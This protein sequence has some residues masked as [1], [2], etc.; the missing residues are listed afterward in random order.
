M[1]HLKRNKNPVKIVE[2]IALYTFLVLGSVV[3]LAPLIWMLS[4]AS[5]PLEETLSPRFHLIP[6]HFQLFKN[7]AA[8]FQET[9]LLIFFKNSIIVG[10]TVTIGQV[11]LCAMAGY[12]FAKFNYWGRDTLFRVVLSTMLIPF[13][14]VI[15]PLYI[16]VAQLGISYRLK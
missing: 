5:K 1:L 15:L 11:L 2:R 9:N 16:V 12:S 10:V 8:A 3:M 6:Q 13:Y 4:T 7:L 14:V